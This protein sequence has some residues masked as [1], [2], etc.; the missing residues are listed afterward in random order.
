MMGEGGEDGGQVPDV[1]TCLMGTHRSPFVG[2]QLA[3]VGPFERGAA[4]LVQPA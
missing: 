4:C 3:D 1:P 2:L